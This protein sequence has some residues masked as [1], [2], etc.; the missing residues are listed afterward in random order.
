M[1]TITHH[2]QTAIA[3]NPGKDV[4]RVAWNEGHDFSLDKSDVGLSNVDNTT[5]ASKLAAAAAAAAVQYRPKLSANTTVNVPSQH[6]TL[7]AALA[8][9]TTIDFNNFTLTIQLAA[10][11][12]T[13]V[14]NVFTVPATVGQ[15][16]ARNLL[17]RGDPT[18]PAN[19][20][21]SGTTA[22]NGL[23]EVGPGARVRIQGMK[24]VGGGNTFGIHGNGGGYYE[25]LDCE[26]STGF[27]AAVASESAATS[28]CFGAIT[29]SGNMVGPVFATNGG[30]AFQIGSTVTIG[31]GLTWGAGYAFA[32][33]GAFI[34]IAGGTSFPGSSPTGP[35]FTSQRNSVIDVS[36]AGATYLPG[37]TAGVTAT[38]GLY[39]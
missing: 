2:H 9:A 39:S 17:V 6:A 15:S 28:A 31:A 7:E 38:G 25:Y 14:S 33:A 30:F 4:S 13:P 29:I 19:V 26:F 23:F 18:T 36:G 12:Y 21:I 22:F 3:D 10:G 20:V 32:D 16:T 1:G 5:D 34:R 37:S 24:F 35:R 11:T 8:Y 27:Y